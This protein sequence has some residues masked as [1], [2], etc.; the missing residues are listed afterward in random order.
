M[1]RMVL[2]ALLMCAFATRARADIYTWTDADGHLH[3]DDDAANVPAAQRDA[4]RVT[5]SKPRVTDEQPSSAQTATQSAYSTA[6]ARELGLQT[7]TTQDPV[8]LLHLVGIYPAVG[9]Y[10]NAPLTPAVVQEV[11]SSTRAAA[12]AHRL[13]QSEAGA[14]SIALRVA[15]SLGVATPPPAAV[16]DP[17]PPQIVVAPNIVVETPPQQTVVVTHV[18]APPPPVIADYPFWGFGIP[19]ATTGAVHPQHVNSPGGPAGQLGGPLIAPLI[20][21]VGVGPRRPGNP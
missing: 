20:A 15:S 8:S 13:S 9:W 17:A 19:F 14:E 2:I 4:A 5:R 18:E 16:P 21:P 12:R 7:S 6:L 11:V 10:P 3:F 1:K